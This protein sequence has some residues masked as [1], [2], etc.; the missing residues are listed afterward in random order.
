[1]QSESCVLLVPQE[2]ANISGSGYPLAPSGR[3]AAH[4]Q[5]L[6]D[7]VLQDDDRRILVLAWEAPFTV[8]SNEARLNAA[9]VGML[10]SM[11]LITTQ[12]LGGG[13][14]DTWRITSIGMLRLQREPM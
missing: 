13:Y 7:A 10:A 1:M 9:S 6:T 11:G 14:G 3:K 5:P 2:P 8:K 12:R 4:G